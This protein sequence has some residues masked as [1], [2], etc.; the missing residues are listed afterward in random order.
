MQERPPEKVTRR[1]AVI[2]GPGGSSRNLLDVVAPLLGKD[3]ALEMQQ[4][5]PSKWQ[6][7]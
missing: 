3:R 5:Q 4:Q 6:G 2:L 7:P 1:V